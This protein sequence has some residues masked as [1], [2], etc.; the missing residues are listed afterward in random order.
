MRA[1]FILMDLTLI[2]TVKKIKSKIGIVFQKSVLDNELTVLQNLY[3]RASLYPMSKE[4]AK[5]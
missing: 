1:K 3:S 5:K 2:R 4:E